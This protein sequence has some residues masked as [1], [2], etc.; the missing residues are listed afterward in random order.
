MYLRGLG[1]LCSSAAYNQAQLALIFKTIL[2]GLQLNQYVINRF[3][4]G[5]GCMHA[6]FPVAL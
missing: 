2:C 1:S 3:W 5:W 6:Y 4:S